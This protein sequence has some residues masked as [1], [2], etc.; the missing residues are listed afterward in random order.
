[1]VSSGVERSITQLRAGVW[2]PMDNDG[3]PLEPI[4]TPETKPPA[5][6]SVYA[7]SKYVQERMCLMIGRA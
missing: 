2:E 1:V 3:N 5:L 4:A 7:L 6:S